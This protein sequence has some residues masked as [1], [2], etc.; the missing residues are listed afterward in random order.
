MKKKTKVFLS[1]ALAVILLFSL[2]TPALASAS[3]VD[4]GIEYYEDDVVTEQESPQATE[5]EG[6]S[7][8]GVGM[9]VFFAIVSVIGVAMPIIPLILGI[10]LP[11]SKKLQKPR[12]W[13]AVSAAS[14]VWMISGFLLL[15]TTVIMM[16][17]ASMP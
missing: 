9:I 16:I 6:I 13:Y 17:I 12:G 15:V 2:L 1:L 14:L 8:E 3:V 11:R 10:L 7:I 5:K 4:D